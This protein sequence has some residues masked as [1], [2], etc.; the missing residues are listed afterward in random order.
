MYNFV[1][2]LRPRVECMLAAALIFLLDSLCI[3]LTCEHRLAPFRI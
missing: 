2:V 1:P 3:S